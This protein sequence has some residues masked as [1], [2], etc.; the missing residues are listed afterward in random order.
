MAPQVGQVP[1]GVAAR[2]ALVRLLARVHAQVPFEVVEVRGCVG[3]VWAA[4][5]FLL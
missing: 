5:R 3:A 4:M 2:R 1:A